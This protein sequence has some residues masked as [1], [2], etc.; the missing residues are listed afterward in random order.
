M[1]IEADKVDKIL[2][3]SDMLYREVALKTDSLLL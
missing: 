3:Y 2:T 1:F